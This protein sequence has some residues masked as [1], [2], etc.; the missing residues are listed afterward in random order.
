MDGHETQEHFE[1]LGNDIFQYFGLGCR[2]VSKLFVPE[3]YD[4]DAFFK[5]MYKFNSFINHHKYANNYDYNK[6]V[7]LM[8]SM[9]LLD[10]GFLLLKEDQQF[11]SPIGTLFYE[12]YSS[13][14]ELKSTL[15]HRKDEIQCIVGHQAFTDVEF[16]NTQKPQ[17]WD[18]AD[19]VDTMTFLIEQ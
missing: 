16:G 10:N 6:A 8:S 14:S 7:Y 2:N 18:Y 11:S 19:G 1:A 13:L 5:A 9:N 4:F 12:S 3:D 17:L 15:Q